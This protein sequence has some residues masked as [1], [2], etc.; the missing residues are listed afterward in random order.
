[1]FANRRFSFKST[2]VFRNGDVYLDH[3]PDEVT[4]IQAYVVN[5]EDNPPK[6]LV[7]I[8]IKDI[9]IEREKEYLRDRGILDPKAYISLTPEDAIKF[10]RQINTLVSEIFKEDNYVR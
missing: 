7:H 4:Y 2:P 9:P 3:D 8:T 5:D 1:M 10:A 6:T